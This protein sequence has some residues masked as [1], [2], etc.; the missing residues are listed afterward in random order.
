MATGARRRSYQITTGAVSEWSP[1]GILVFGFILLL[2]LCNTSTT[3]AF[4]PLSPNSS[5]HPRTEAHP[6]WNNNNNE[7]NAESLNSSNMDST[8]TTNGAT[9]TTTTTTDASSSSQTNLA[10]LIC[11]AQFCVPADYDDVCR[12]LVS[13]S[14]QQ[15]PT[16]QSC[17]TVPLTRADWLRVTKQL[18]TRAYLQGELPVATTL[19]FYM[20]AIER[21]LMEVLNTCD[22]DIAIVGHSIGGWIARAYLGGLSQSATAVYPLARQRVRSLV[23][24]GT[25]HQVGAIDQ[26]RG[27]L[28]AVEAAPSCSPAA[29]AAEAGIRVTCVASRAVGSKWWEN[30]LAWGSYASFGGSGDAVGDGIVPVETSL[31]EPPAQRVVLD[32]PQ[33]LHV[34]PTPWKVWD[35]KGPSMPLPRKVPHYLSDEV[36]GEWIRYL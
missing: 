22:S 21:G 16:I 15:P 24:L 25:P 30:P 28:R 1:R 4:A 5:L 7:P 19:R 11:P 3:L 14:Q 17:T 23:T 33:H 34:L 8:T 26:T 9:T 35:G 31:L 32:T 20:D 6:H 2:K 12:T 10:V 13:S 18:P 27:L 36:V 29:L